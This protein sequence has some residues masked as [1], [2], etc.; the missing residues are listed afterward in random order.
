[1]T[2]FSGGQDQGCDLL[3]HLLKKINAFGAN[4]DC[5]VFTFGFRS[6]KTLESE[7][8]LPAIFFSRHSNFPSWL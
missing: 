4:Q 8:A 2:R 1:M 7:Q 3:Y 5:Q 6:I